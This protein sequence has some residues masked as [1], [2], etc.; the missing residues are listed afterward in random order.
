MVRSLGKV[1]L[2]DRVKVRLFHELGI[3]L[4]EALALGQS[5]GIRQGLG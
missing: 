1:L 4:G 5:F 3:G 2:A